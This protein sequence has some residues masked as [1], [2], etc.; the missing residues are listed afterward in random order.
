M[1]PPELR[2][3]MLQMLDGE[4]SADEAAALEAE[5]MANPE[6]R[7]EWWKLSRLH[8]ALESRFAAAA[9]I[10]LSPVVP[11]DLV[12]A[13]QR[14]R[15]VKIALTAAAAV[16]TITAIA[17]WMISAPDNGPAL[18]TLRTAPGSVVTVTHAEDRKHPDSRALREGSRLTLDHGVAEL[19]L[20]HEVRAVV[21][22]PAVLKL[23]DS[24]TLRLDHGQAFFE[25]KSTA[26]RGFAVVTPR[27]RIVDL[28]TAFGVV[29]NGGGDS[30]TELHVF[31]GL[32]RVDP[33][34]GEQGE[35]VAAGRSVR[36]DGHRVTEEIASAPVSFLR[37]L[38]ES[39]ETL[40]AEDFSTGL[41]AD[42]QY[43]VLIDP[44]MILGQSGRAFP[45]IAENEGW[46]FRTAPAAPDNIP[47][48]NPGFEE[49]GKIIGH[50]AAIA[51][52]HDAHPDQW[53]WGVD[54]RR[55]NL[56][57]TEGRFFGRV[58]SGR[59]LRQ[60]TG[61]TIRPGVTYILTLDVGL[62]DSAA[63]VRLHD[64]DSSAVLAET[65]LSSS[66][67]TWLRNQSLVFT[68]SNRHDSGGRL[69]ISLTC[70]AGHF[71]AFDR[72]RVGTPGHMALNG[73]TLAETAPPAEPSEDTLPGSGNAPPQIIGMLPAANETAAIPGGPL[74]LRFDQPVKRGNGRIVLRNITDW[75]E[76]VFGVGDPRLSLDGPLLTIRPPLELDDG[77][78]Q[79]GRLGGWQSDAWAG[80]FNPAGD[81]DRY[82]NPAFKG[83]PWSRGPMMATLAA[84]A[85]GAGIRREIGTI[86][87][88]RRYTA[89]VAI[90]HR[91]SAASDPAGFAGYT[92]RLVSGSTVL[93]GR[94]G[95]TPPGPPNTVET[96][97][98]AW[99]ATRLPETI[100]PGDPLA[101]E[102]STHPDS[103]DGYLDIDSVRVTASP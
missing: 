4:L 80:V 65:T 12:L 14:R 97:A 69:A 48:R 16:L 2:K 90:G 73:F 85:P 81:G 87:P 78:I 6:A 23:I 11:I 56:V 68:A 27:Q 39:V 66:R 53:G 54:S 74:M 10:R 95:H 98:L 50:G 5:L 42:R 28:G 60:N 58:F 29:A 47:V 45:G 34:A 77:E 40:L 83:R 43:S 24:R 94:T 35:T 49:D 67:E 79:M 96:V 93:A 26:G 88:G 72:I 99:D 63:T 8:S 38:P 36:L 17:L 44:G 31:E 86:E 71:A 9:A 13:H 51:G 7:D 21:Q 76:T 84:G 59:T 1:I 103:T 64:G 32:V 91:D 62:S 46:T 61:E 55:N 20:P 18:A 25:V 52:W 41:R 100:A 37:E 102:I 70:S 89:S 22:A 57:P 75:S 30:S 82:R 19:E 101:I 3:R 92:I 15:M 33:P